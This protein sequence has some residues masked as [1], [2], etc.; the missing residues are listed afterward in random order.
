MNKEKIKN[1]A[2]MVNTYE[3]C[4]KIGYILSPK[5]ATKIEFYVSMGYKLNLNNPKS[6]NEKIN[7]LKFNDDLNLKTICADKL[8]VRSYIKNKGYENLLNKIYVDGV[9]SIE[10]IDFS[11]LPKKFVI[12][13]NH[14]CGTNIMV[15]DKN[16]LDI[17]KI[18][19][20]YKIWMKEKY[21]KVPYEPQY[22]NIEP[23]IIVEENLCDKE[24]EILEDYKFYC[25][26]GKVMMFSIII[27]HPKP[28]LPHIYHFDTNLNFIESSYR[29]GTKIYQL[30][31][32]TSII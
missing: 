18:K 5:L 24:N 13:T 7:Y 1:N 25:S 28:E 31:P 9:D 22:L 32:R 14:S 2:F 19:K 6:F 3:L 16:K 21:G 8:K 23:K 12:K 29:G 4:R 11:K 15:F 17:E 20:Q 26:K 10:Q 27:R 30:F